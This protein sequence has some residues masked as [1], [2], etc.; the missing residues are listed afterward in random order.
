MDGLGLYFPL[1]WG[2]NVDNTNYGYISIYGI[3]TNNGNNVKRRKPCLDQDFDLIFH[4]I[5]LRIITAVSSQRVTAHELA[6]ALPDIPQYDTLPAS[7]RPG[8]GEVL[9]DVVEE[10]PILVGRWNGCTPCRTR[11]PSHRKICAA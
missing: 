11:R 9:L 7:Q 10:N 1:T 2:T 8:G 6:E 4:P 3:I 5:R